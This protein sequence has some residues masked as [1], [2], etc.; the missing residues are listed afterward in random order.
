MA[1][2]QTLSPRT[3]MTATTLRTQRAAKLKHAVPLYLML[4]PAIAYFVI[5]TYYPLAHAVLISMQNFRFIGNRPFVGF[6]NYV[7]VLSDSEFWSSFANTSILGAGILVIGFVAPIVIALSL[8]EV[9]QSWLKRT[10]Q[11]VIYIPHLFSW[12][13]VGGLWIYM[14]TPDG[15]LVNTVLQVLHLPQVQF[16]TNPNLARWVLILVTVWKEVGFNCILY[17]AAIVGINP[18]LYES[19]R[20]DG[21]TR[22]HEMWH[23][24]IPMLRRT[25]KVVG[26]LSIMGL[27]RLFQQIYVMRNAVIEP[28]VDVLMTYVYDKGLQQMNIGQATASALL[29]LLFTLLLTLITRRLV[30]Y[31]EL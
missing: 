9:L 11:M 1:S 30:Q 8:N 28:K 17:L 29:I 18:A 23:V 3:S 26:L 25:M 27:L 2:T 6:Q 13:V 24:T 22:W 21:A 10:I 4:L 31:N 5:M 7:D 15:G 20:V 16:M 12:V 19:A 14:L